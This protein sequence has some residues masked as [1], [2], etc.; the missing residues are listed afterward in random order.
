MNHHPDK[1]QL[2]DFAADSLKKNTFE[3]VALHISKCEQ[4]RS[5]VK[6][7]RTI[8]KESDNA[9]LAPPPGI[10]TRILGLLDG[11]D[12]KSYR[13]ISLKSGIRILLRP[14]AYTSIVIIAA[15][16][17]FIYTSQKSSVV[18]DEAMLTLSQHKGEVLHNDSLLQKKDVKSGIIRTKEYSS[19]VLI[20]DSVLSL[21]IAENSELSIINAHKYKEKNNI[22]Y[23]I[24]LDMK[25]GSI[26]ASSDYNIRKK[27][28]ISA[29]HAVFEALGTS[30]IISS[31]D[32][33]SKLSVLDGIVRATS[34]SDGKVILLS[35]GEGCTVSAALLK[36]TTINPEHENK[37]FVYQFNKIKPDKRISKEKNILR[38]NEADNKGTNQTKDGFS[39]DSEEHSENDRNELKKS[40]EKMQKESRQIQKE[41]RS[42]IKS[43]KRYRQ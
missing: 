2:I 8:L 30:F 1:K 13:Y 7:L 16:S 31:N 20:L 6:S 14:A 24:V 39:S 11:P 43:E 4:C 26:L 28:I 40:R 12:V 3:A 33:A 35:K 37:K 23:N 25:S 9:A 36:K 38:N 41:M 17:I 5:T 19:A 29:K 22:E 10:K 27:F 21:H 42:N 18:S 34:K 32:A 15:L